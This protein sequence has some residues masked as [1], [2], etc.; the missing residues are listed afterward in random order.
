MAPPDQ[1]HYYDITVYA[2]DSLL[3]LQEG[4]SYEQLKESIKSHVLDEANIKGLCYN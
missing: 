2:L 4:F 3:D 1:P